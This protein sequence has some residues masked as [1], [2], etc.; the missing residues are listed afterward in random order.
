MSV[1]LRTSTKIAIWRRGVLRALVAAL[2][3]CPCAAMAQT[4]EG[5]TLPTTEVVGVSPVAG[6]GIDPDKIP[7]NVPQPLGPDRMMSGPFIASATV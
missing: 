5:V 7:A 4:E 6:S 3:I 1:L 2:A